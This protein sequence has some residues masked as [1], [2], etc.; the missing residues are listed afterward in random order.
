[1]KRLIYLFAILL[2]MQLWAQEIHVTPDLI[3]DFYYVEGYGP[4]GVKSFVVSASGLF[5]SSEVTDSLVISA[6]GHFEIRINPNEDF[7]TTL[8]LPANDT[9]TIV[10]TTI[11]VQMV[12]NLDAG[13]YEEDIVIS[14]HNGYADP[15]SVRCRGIVESPPALPA[16][17]F[18]P[19]GDT[20]YGQQQ[21]SI[22]CDTTTA[23]IKYR[24]SQDDEWIDYTRPF[25][26]DRDMTIWAKATKEGY[27]E[28]EI[29]S[30][31]Y[32]ILYRITVT[33][34]PE[35]GGTITMVDGDTTYHYDE[36]ATLEARP[37]DGYSFTA[38][39]N[40]ETVNPLSV[41]V[42][43]DMNI[44]AIFEP[45]SYQVRI[46]ID[47]IEG[48]TFEGG[49]T[50]QYGDYCTIKAT[51]NI[52]YV[53]INWT[54]D[55]EEFSDQVEYTFQCY[56]S[57]SLVAHFLLTELP[58][59]EGDIVIP[60]AICAGDSL[61]LTTPEVHLADSVGWQISPYPSFEAYMTYTQQ[62]L[63]DNYDSWY[64][65]HDGWYLRYMAA[66]HA[67]VCYS[68]MVTINVHPVLDESEILKIVGKKCGDHVDHILVYPKSGYKYQWYLDDSPINDTTQYIHSANG[69]REG[70]YR[71]EIALA[72]DTNGEL[73]CP[74]SSE[75]YL[76]S[77]SSKMVYPNPVPA[78][79]EIYVTND[80][81]YEALFSIYSIDG[82]LVHQ[83]MVNA[84][85]NTILLNLSKGIYVS[86]L[87][88]GSDTATEKIVIQ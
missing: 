74:I 58:T 48:G 29:V 14:S 38:W 79:T 24:F 11:H 56:K 59:I 57:H 13:T 27:L 73:L 17:R 40:G 87:T 64:L 53:F 81:D 45:N 66:N 72:R 9:G 12:K 21:V 70:T 75:N 41:H 68:N 88:N 18:E 22:V 77:S 83:Q 42:T 7:V 28:S 76:V 6:S 43:E 36:T 80:S 69:L 5:D 37:N 31:E 61:G 49:G 44:Q 19:E 51:A 32:S 86:S 4:S 10:G 82:R 8:Y 52:G 63:E 55:G 30:A 65:N 34:L 39:G 1:M 20:Y 62:Y 16:P 25:A 46:T 54:E 26:V 47:P 33:A 60:E 50:Y 84:G 71:V 2:P 23:I 78:N 67:G 15:V 85:E 35:E 3:D